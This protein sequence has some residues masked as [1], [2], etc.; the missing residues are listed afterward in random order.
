VFIDGD[1]ASWN[2]STCCGP[3]IAAL[4]GT[5]PEAVVL[6][7]LY[8]RGAD[9]SRFWKLVI[10][11]RFPSSKTLNPRTTPGAS[12]GTFGRIGIYCS[13]A[14]K[15]SPLL[16]WHDSLKRPRSGGKKAVSCRR[17]KDPARLVPTLFGY[18]YRLNNV[19]A[20]IG[21]SQCAFIDRVATRAGAL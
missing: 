19:L 16:E 14:I 18:N 10:A 4:D 11:M 13:M 3:W 2:N 6:V 1:R 7:H 5:L 20:G 8:G 21:R 15:L 17:W 9:V 12:P